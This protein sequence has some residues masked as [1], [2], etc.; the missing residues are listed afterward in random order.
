M[1]LYLK[2]TKLEVYDFTRRLL[3]ACYEVVKKFPP[4]EQFNLTF[5][6]RKA[7][8][9]VLLNLAEGSSR[10]S[11]RERK[12][13][14]EVSRSSAV[15]IDS[16]FDAAVDLKYVAIEDLNETGVILVSVFR[17]LS[18]MINPGKGPGNG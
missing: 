4:G 7:A 1:F 8:L 5:Q 10:K 2:H 11:P 9:S 16:A 14:F 13:F 6:I 17:M 18:K 3:I 15:E 12:R